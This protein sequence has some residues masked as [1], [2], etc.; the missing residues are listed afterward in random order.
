MCC[1]KYNIIHYQV[2]VQPFNNEQADYKWQAM[3][4]WQTEIFWFIIITGK[5]KRKKKRKVKRNIYIIGIKEQKCN[6]SSKQRVSGGKNPLHI[7]AFT[8]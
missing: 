6:N 2:N 8:L 1:S 3:S 7:I 5:R 4:L